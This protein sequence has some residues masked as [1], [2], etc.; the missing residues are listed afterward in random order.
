MTVGVS[1]RPTPL[2]AAVAEDPRTLSAR[3][4]ALGALLLTRLPVLAIGA[5]AVLL[6]GT[7]PPPVAEALWRVSTDELPNLLARWDPRSLL[8]CDDRYS[9]DPAGFHPENVGF[10]PLYPMLMRFGGV[11]LGG[12][13]LLAAILVSLTA[14]TAAIALLYR[15]AL[16]DVG[17][18]Y[19]WRAILLL[20]AFPYAVFYSAAYTESLFLLLSVAAFY[21]M[22]RGRLTMVALAGLAAGLTRPNGFWLSLPLAL[23]AMGSLDSPAGRPG[24]RRWTALAV[25]CAP[26]VGVAIY[27]AYLHFRFDDAL[28]WV[29]GQRAWGV[30][31]V[32][33][34][35][36]PDPTRLPGEPALTVEEVI[37]WIGNIA[38]FGVAAAAC[39]PIARRF[40]AAYAVWIA[41]NIFPPVPAHLFLSLGRFTAILFPLFF[42]LALRIPRRHLVPVATAFAVG[43]AVLAVW[44]FLWKPVV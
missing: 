14:F 11:L 28:A 18:D 10:F 32:G 25:A 4:V 34:R 3:T 44:F 33:Q 27:S 5:L 15:L 8:D 24:S 38:A 29:H 1:E 39:V 30:A 36:A 2:L 7:K 26:I 37:T 16:L 35:G 21:A 9:L 43:Q 20:A 17:A 22:R 41:V 12:H 13:P 19:A 40:G 42:W 31:I 23:L 6:V